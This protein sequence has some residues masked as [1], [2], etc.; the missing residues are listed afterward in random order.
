MNPILVESTTL[1]MVAYDAEHQILH[2]EFRDRRAYR[3]FEVPVDVYQSLIGASSKGGF[4]NRL[5]RGRFAY[6]RIEVT[7]LS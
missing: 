6:A 3:Y 4:F 2:L 1:K 5:V 7:S